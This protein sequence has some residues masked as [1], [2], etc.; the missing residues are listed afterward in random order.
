MREDHGNDDGGDFSHGSPRPLLRSRPRASSALSLL[1][2]SGSNRTRDLFESGSARPKTDAH[3]GEEL[4]WAARRRRP[5]WITAADSLSILGISKEAV[6]KERYLQVYSVRRGME[7]RKSS[8]SPS[9]AC[10]QRTLTPTAWPTAQ[11]WPQAVLH[12]T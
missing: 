5:R 1:V 11:T 12:E 4:Q 10:M 7:M 9:V 2:R 6:D 3:R 8:R